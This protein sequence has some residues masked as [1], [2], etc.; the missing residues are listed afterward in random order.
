[1]P[2]TEAAVATARYLSAIPPQALAQAVAY[3]HAQHWLY[4]GS[5]ILTL[6]ACLL[7]LRLG[8]LDR[9]SARMSRTTP[10]P[11]IT[12]FACTVAFLACRWLILSPYEVYAGW[13]TES[14]FGQ[15]RQSLPE[16]I[17]A[18]VGQELVNAVF[19]GLLAGVLYWLIRRTG[20]KW[21]ILGATVAGL[22]GFVTIAIV[23][24]VLP[25]SS[26]YRELPAGRVRAE[27]QA[28]ADAARV[29]GADIKVF[30]DPDHPDFYTANVSG[31]GPL[32]TISLSRAVL[33]DP[34]DAHALRAVVAHELGHYV[35]AD[36]MKLGLAVAAIVFVG[37]FLADRCF[38][39]LARTMRPAAPPAISD[40]VGLPVFS[41]FAILF[42]LVT[43]PVVLAVQRGI[44]TR[45]DAY[46]L[47]LAGEPDGAARGLVAT[48]GYRAPSPTPLEEA[49][50]YDHPSIERRVR[51][52]MDW[53]A[54]HQRGPAGP[55]DD[56][57]PTS[58]AR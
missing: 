39:A 30:D 41:A 15:L 24:A 26:S 27:V 9:I 17:G 35:E 22:V 53:K 34:L 32:R 5:K 2:S 13:Y 58:Q 19:T 46:G 40:P 54:S 52:A 37:L 48:A 28:L 49:L 42:S 8:I 43:L 25:T 57:Y 50:F 20:R 3:T 7:I 33:R 47:D 12:A 31:V 36:P 55:T 18:T 23:P 51:A 38:P 6:A 29:R 10:R 45:A 11:F 16:W 44:E 4:A 56:G 21:W 14:R 1:M